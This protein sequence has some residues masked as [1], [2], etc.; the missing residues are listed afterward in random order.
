MLANR[1][2]LDGRRVL[3]RKTVEHMTLNHLPGGVDLAAMGQR[4][5]SEISY[6]GIGFGLGF[7]V[8]LDP[9][10]AGVIGSVGEHGWGGAASTMFW[11]DRSEELVGM[12][13]TQ[14][15]PSSTHPIRR[16]LK[17]L[18]YQALID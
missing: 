2:E 12:V 10:R 6:D 5:F 14:L 15:M 3:G 18:V 16:E 4:V 1:G 13:L 11:V 9:A 17:A 7:S 8:M